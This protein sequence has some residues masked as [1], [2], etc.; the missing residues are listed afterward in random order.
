MKRAIFYVL[1]V[2]VI[3][4][5][6]NRMSLAVPQDSV[7]KDNYGKVIGQIVDAET[8]ENVKEKFLITLY[9]RFE[10]DRDNSRIYTDQNGHFGQYRYENYLYQAQTSYI[11]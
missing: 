3:S 6:N 1:I 8:G 5:I 7:D 10:P 11:M 2:L 4:I 9:R